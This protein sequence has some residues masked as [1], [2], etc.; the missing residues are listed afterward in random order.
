MS[1]LDDPGLIWR[2]GG[3]PASERF[4]DIYFS[5]GDGLAETRHV[6]I[7]G[8]GAPDIWRGKQSFTIGELGFGTGLNFLT[9]WKCW[10]KTAPPEARLHYV[11]IEGFPLETDAL[12]KTLEAFPELAGEAAELCP[13][14]PPR[15]PG[16]HLVHLDKGRVSLLLIYAPVAIALDDLVATVD[17]W[18]LDGFA[19]SKNPD[20]WTGDIL[21]AVAAHSRHGARIATFT[22]AGA[23]RRGLTAAGFD[24]EK[25][26]GFGAKRDQIIGRFS[27]Q[28]EAPETKPWYAF[29][30]R[31]EPPKHITVIG[32]GIGGA[33]LAHALRAAGAQ[34]RVIDKG[35]GPAAEASG[36]PA[37][38]IQP[39]PLNDASPA[40]AFHAATYLYASRFYNDLDTAW[41]H[42]G[43]MVF[44]RDEDDIRRFSTLATA[45]TLPSTHVKP[46]DAV[47]TRDVA[48]IDP[49]MGG[50]WFPHA[51]ALDTTAAC[52]E[53]LG[54]TS[55]HFE[56]EISK[57]FQPDAD[58]TIIA[59]GISSPALAGFDHMG[60]VENRGQVSFLPASPASRDLK[61][62][63]MFGGY[64]TP[65]HKGRHILGATFNRA[66]ERRPEEWT[67]VTESDHQR[68]LTTLQSRL[69]KLAE[70]FP[71][72]DDGWTGIRATTVDR[73]PVLGGVPD[74]EAYLR[75]Y[76]DLHHGR[77]ISRYPPAQYQQN[78]Y[79]AAGFGSHGF[80]VAP[81][82]AQVLSAII[83]GT[84]LPVPKD[85]AL[86]LHPARFLIRDLRR[87][88]V[89]V[90]D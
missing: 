8:I 89:N 30:E 87:R 14:L 84:P 35:P 1:S 80:T 64:L 18:Y 45:G 12:A 37:G 15:H 28:P 17:A 43:L 52:R 51:G 5:A 67:A 11:S 2:D 90:I 26:P 58:A 47:Q 34:V 41:Q 42:R 36:N 57:N 54:D 86:A 71:M 24:V 21:R 44:G 59:A 76:G 22:A 68:N 46:L 4:G 50:V 78:L 63:I 56:T 13:A 73:L 19:P 40:A 23:V 70:A 75:D 38:V 81:L 62:A 7:D 31:Q 77:H 25:R 10:R 27:G 72:A 79:V 82:A 60:I 49:G 69:P 65:A 61:C 74:G 85:V 39:R 16:F 66:H 33:T 6:F 48:G 53:I 29:P 83:M 88:R 55:C 9:T 32:A 20:M 3:T